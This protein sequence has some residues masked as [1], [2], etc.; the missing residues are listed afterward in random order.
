MVL[1]AS[2][3]AHHFSKR[4]LPPFHLQHSSPFSTYLLASIM[5]RTGNFSVRFQARDGAGEYE[6]QDRGSRATNQTQPTATTDGR[7]PSYSE[8]SQ[9]HHPSINS[10]EKTFGWR[11]AFVYIGI[12]IAIGL[13]TYRLIEIVTYALSAH[14]NPGQNDTE[15]QVILPNASFA[16]M[17]LSQ[18]SPTTSSVVPGLYFMPATTLFSQWPRGSNVFPTTVNLEIGKIDPETKL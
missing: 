13:V 3:S 7:P 6:L 11:L 9:P 17:E 14:T 15:S 1:T 2:A 4:I 12:G 18:G 10:R 8:N 16:D 5:V